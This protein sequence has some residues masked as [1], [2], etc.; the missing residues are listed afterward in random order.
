MNRVLHLDRTYDLHLSMMWHG[1]NVHEK[2]WNNHGISGHVYEIIDYYLLL[3]EYFKVGILLCEDIDW[4][5]LY[6]AI[7]YKYDI[8]DNIIDEIKQ[9]TTFY[10]RPKI[11]RG[12]NILFVDGGLKRGGGEAPP[13]LVFNN[14]I[15]FRCSIYDTHYDLPYSNLTLLQDNRVYDDDDNNIA[16]DYIKKINFKYYKKIKNN[17]SRTGMLYITNNCRLLTDQQLLAI[18]TKYDFDRFLILT[19]SPHAYA[20]RF[21]KYDNFEFPTLPVNNIFGKF[22]THIYTRT[23]SDDE[24]N[25]SGSNLPFDCSPR[26]IA[27]CKY[28][29]KDVI[30][31]NIDDE[32][33]NNDT[34]LKY[35]KYD[36]DNDFSSLFLDEQ[37]A[38]IDIIKG[39]LDQ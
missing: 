1:Y 20:H 14:I 9:H 30:Y 12:K 22:N 36:I 8:D 15:C 13:L 11:V 23:R 6:N 28:Y 3:R 34:G 27:E 37:D 32:Y 33:L 24:P 7:I 31:D 26:F 25:R 39:K 19:S 29:D 16:I 4:E 35:R 21:R 2:R 17:V 10:N 38:L 5:I 18:I